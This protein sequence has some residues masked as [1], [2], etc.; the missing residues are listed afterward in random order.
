MS[1]ALVSRSWST[2]EHLGVWAPDRVSSERW[3]TGRYVPIC[4]SERNHANG[5]PI[6]HHL[7]FDGDDRLDPKPLCS[8][9]RRLLADLLELAEGDPRP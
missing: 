6:V 8:R 2:V 4:N 9:C 5:W 7:T 3:A 1:V